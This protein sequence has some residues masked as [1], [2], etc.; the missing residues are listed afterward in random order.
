M[1]KQQTEKMSLQLKQN[2]AF[3]EGKSYCRSITPKRRTTP[4][5][6]H[7]RVVACLRKAGLI[8]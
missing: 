4:E 1:P 3:A 5:R 8:H 2:S 7:K 6:F